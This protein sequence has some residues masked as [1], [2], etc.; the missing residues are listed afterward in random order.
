MTERWAVISDIHANI[1]A[2]EAV[3]RDMDEQRI[4]R[5][6]VLGDT[7]N[8]GGAPR[9][10]I[11]LVIS[12]ADSLIFGNHEAAVLSLGKS[13]PGM[14]GAAEA[15]LEWTARTLNQSLLWNK[16]SEG[17]TFPNAAIALRD[18]VQLVHGSPREPV[19]E[20]VWPGHPSYF[21]AFND[22]L[23]QRLRQMLDAR[24]ALHCFC[25]HTHVPAILLPYDQRAVL[26]GRGWDR[27]FSFIGPTTVFFVPN[28]PM[29]ID[30]LRDVPVIINP[31]SVGQPRDGRPEA[32]YM[33]YDG[34]SVEFRRVPYDVEAAQH[35]ILALPIPRDARL[36]LAQRLARGE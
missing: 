6:V 9:E 10:C 30:G 16:L 27:L 33:I 12:V 4:D 20:Y 14:V 25:G 15:G 13:D 18:G 34:D 1:D 17:A 5:L 19:A 29:V 35:R 22:Q 3:L 32:S 23:D 11:E 2:F 24:M 36:Y 28:Q 26:K 7:V 21:L 8:Y 31:G